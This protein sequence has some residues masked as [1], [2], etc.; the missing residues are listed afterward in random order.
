VWIICGRQLSP[1]DDRLLDRQLR[2]DDT[3]LSN[4]LLLL[5]ATGMRIGECLHLLPSFFQWTTETAVGPDG[6]V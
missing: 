4:T 1:E 2:A 5:R 3:L 6:L